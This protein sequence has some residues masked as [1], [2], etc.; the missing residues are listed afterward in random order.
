MQEPGQALQLLLSILRSLSAAYD[1]V[2]AVLELPDQ[3]LQQLLRDAAVLQQAAIT[4]GV[5]LQL[6][7]S[8]TAAQTQVGARWVPTAHFQNTA[9]CI[10]C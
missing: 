7:C 5:H 10:T 3:L 6:L 8:F 9:L 1:T 2:F 4:Y